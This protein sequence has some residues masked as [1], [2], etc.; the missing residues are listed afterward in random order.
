MTSDRPPVSLQGM[1][2]RLFTRFKWGLTAELERPDYDLR[3]SILS[4][5]I[6]HD[7]LSINK[8]VIDFIAK[9]VTD[10]VR[11]LEGIVVSLMAHATI[12]NREISLELAERVISTSVKIEKKQITI[13]QIGRA[14]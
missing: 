14:E 12:F 7:G 4:N 5:K 9:N 1:V 8:E 3:R 6:R 2:P 10:N 13:E 11:D